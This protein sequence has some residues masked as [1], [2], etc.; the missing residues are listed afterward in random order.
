MS[1]DE[2]YADFSLSRQEQ[3]N[4]PDLRFADKI[5][6]LQISDLRTGTLQKYA[7]LQLRNEPQKLWICDL[8]TI[9]ILY[10]FWLIFILIL[11]GA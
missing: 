6:F 5:F 7:D 1:Y 9:R 8:P 11:Q 4:L 2:K 10:F 3:Q